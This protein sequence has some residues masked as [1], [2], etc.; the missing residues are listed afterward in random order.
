M[1]LDQQGSPWRFWSWDLNNN[2]ESKA[3]LKRQG[4]QGEGWS[5]LNFP[6]W[7]N[8]MYKGPEFIGLRSRIG[9]RWEV[10]GRPDH[11]GPGKFSKKFVFYSGWNRNLFLKAREGCDWIWVSERSL[12]LLC[13]RQT[14]FGDEPN[15]E[16][17]AGIQCR[18]DG[19]RC[20]RLRLGWRQCRWWDE[21]LYRTYFEGRGDRHA[22][23][24]D[25]ECEGMRESRWVLGFW[26]Q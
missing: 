22:E 18:F 20:L 19:K 6:S 24:L 21:G 11:A 26:P 4:S 2:E 14:T 16:A 17:V 7:R 9:Q 15:L 5:E 3:A 12:C 13:R 1:W 25:T 23:G 8:S 10:K